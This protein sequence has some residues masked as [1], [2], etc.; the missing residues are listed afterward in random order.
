MGLESIFEPGGGVPYKRKANG[1]Y[2]YKK[3]TDDSEYLNLIIGL[4]L[5]G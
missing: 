2:V 1:D 3:I 5:K 4:I